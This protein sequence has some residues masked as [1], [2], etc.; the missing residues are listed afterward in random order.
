MRSSEADQSALKSRYSLS[1]NLVKLG[2]LLSMIYISKSPSI[3]EVKIILLPSGDQA[4]IKS[5]T[6][7]LVR[8]VWLTGGSEVR[9]GMV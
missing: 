2:P 1:V 9:R 4:G 6:L 3:S 7:L 5:V 8:R